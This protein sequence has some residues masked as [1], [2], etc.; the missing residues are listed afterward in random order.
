V[1]QNRTLLVSKTN[2]FVY[3]E[4]LRNW[5]SL[6][7]QSGMCLTITEMKFSYEVVRKAGRYL[8]IGQLSKNQT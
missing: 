7:W 4:A 5:K 1:Y 2:I 3:Y 8:T 6:K